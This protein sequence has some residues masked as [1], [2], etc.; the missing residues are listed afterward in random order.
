MSLND[1]RETMVAAA[2]KLV[3]LQS[4]PVDFR[5]VSRVPLFS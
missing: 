5:R 2:K 4:L 3:V 1:D